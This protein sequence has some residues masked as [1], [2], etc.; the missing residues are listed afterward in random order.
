MTASPITAAQTIRSG[1]RKGQSIARLT[2]R[3]HR[4]LRLLGLERALIYKMMVLTGIR[5]RELASIT[6]ADVI[7]DRPEP[8]LILSP[9]H[10]KNRRGS[11]IP[12]RADLVNDLKSWLAVRLE[13][14]RQRASR[15][16]GNTEVPT[17]LPPDAKLVRIPGN[18]SGVLLDDLLAAGLARL[19]TG[20]AGKRRIDSSDDRGR[21][22]DVHALRMT[23]ASHLA[24]G[25]VP[26]RTAQ[27]ALRHSRPELTAVTYTDPKLL[28]V[29]GSL[30]SLPGLPLRTTPMVTDRATPCT[31]AP[32][33][34]SRPATAS[35]PV[36]GSNR[37]TGHSPANT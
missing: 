26:L 15:R 17:S 16:T 31:A 21:V 20:P 22:I 32:A 3:V 13:D 12:L 2:P 23:F 34:D 9:R 8:H 25:G 37:R 19:V 6:V 30:R 27:A 1:R 5:K 11:T 10:E 24:A 7:L 35:T 28:D 36:T 33:L 18:L 14:L 4:H 29:A